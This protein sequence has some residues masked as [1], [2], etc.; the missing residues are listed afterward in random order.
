MSSNLRSKEE[1]LGDVTVLRLGGHLV[2][3]E[4]DLEY[5]RLIDRLVESGCVKIVVDL[6]EVD[7]IDSAGVGM[8]VAKLKS[9]RT[10]GGDVKLL[11]LTSRS[12]RLLSLTRLTLAFEIVDS[13]EQAVKSFEAA[14]KREH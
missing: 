8:L 1:H 14:D 5:R 9:V 3:D 13:L 7:Y 2:L 11:N 10:K 12:Q 6:A 4:G